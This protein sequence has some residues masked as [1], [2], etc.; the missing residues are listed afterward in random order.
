MKFIGLEHPLAVEIVV[1][2]WSEAS[3]ALRRLS[4][5]GLDLSHT[6]VLYFGKK[7]KSAFSLK[8]GLASRFSIFTKKRNHLCDVA[9]LGGER[10]SVFSYK[11]WQ[12][13]PAGVIRKGKRLW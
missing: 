1:E 9:G 13:S 3:C 4:L 12:Q 2:E 8:R 7:S 10:H 6:E 11:E 5:E